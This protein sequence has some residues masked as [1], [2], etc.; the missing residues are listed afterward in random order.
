MR[1]TLPIRRTTFEEWMG[2]VDRRLASL[3]GLTH[4]CIADQPWHDWYQDGMPPR[5]AAE[6][7][8][9]NEGFPFPEGH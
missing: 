9:H 2:A 7:A 3:C 8:L 1:R 6:E 4:T 5:Y